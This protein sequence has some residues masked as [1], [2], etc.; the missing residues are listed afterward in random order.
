M[1]P[2]I[3]KPEAETDIERYAHY[4]AHDNDTAAAAF[5]TATEKVFR[6][7]AQF[8]GLGRARK[9]RDP[10]LVGLRSRALPRPYSAWLVFYRETPTA[11]EIIR[12]LHGAMNLPS[13]L[14]EPPEK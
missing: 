11:V 9:W 8:P 7:L 12:V 3:R 14:L 10:R 2:F 6:R 5:V 1:K 4:I 13:R